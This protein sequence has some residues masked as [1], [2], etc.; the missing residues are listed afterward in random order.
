VS[1][2]KKTAVERRH[3]QRRGEHGAKRKAQKADGMG[4]N[5]SPKPLDDLKLEV[6]CDSANTLEILGPLVVCRW[7][8]PLGLAAALVAA[9][10]EV[11]VPVVGHMLV[12]TGASSTCIA[13]DVA[14]ELGLLSHGTGVTFGAHGPGTVQKYVAHFDMRIKDSVRGEV[15]VARDLIASAVPDLNGAYQQAQPKASDGRPVRLI[16][17]LGRDF[18]RHTTLTYEGAEGRLHLRIHLKSLTKLN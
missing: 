11:P 3:A 9:G 16:G 18:L 13:A 14:Q 15:T 5:H 4:P 2:A 6:R 8:V 7:S 1:K 17:L 10:R 12:D